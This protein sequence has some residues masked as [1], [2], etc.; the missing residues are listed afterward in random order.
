MNNKPYLFCGRFYN[1]TK[2]SIVSRMKHMV[3]T[4]LIIS[5]HRK[6][7]KNFVRNARTQ[8][9]ACAHQWIDTAPLIQHSINPVI[10]W[11]GHATF[12]IQ[13]G[14]LNI[15]TDPAFFEISPLIPRFLPSP[16][17]LQQLPPIDLILISHNHRDHMDEQ[18][19]LTLSKHRPA[20]F[21]PLGNVTWLLTR[22]FNKAKEFTWWDETTI[23]KNNTSLRI[24]FL[25]AEHWTGRGL[26]DTNRSLWGSW[27]I[28]YNNTNIY[29]AGDTAWGSHFTAINQKFGPLLAAMLPISPYQPRTLLD[30]CH[31]DAPQSIQALAA[32][33]AQ[34]MFPMHWGTFM[35]GTDSFLGPIEQLQEQ[36]A[37]QQSLIGT[38][39][40]HVCKFCE[41]QALQ[42]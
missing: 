34:H 32:L 27:M 12:L 8:A 35:F 40:L 41:P 10:T 3:H 37:L 28:T 24:T 11:L 20:V 9:A 22:G 4:S 42:P 19:M 31:L 25:P 6:N 1:N 5:K 23:T 26:W 13:V 36:W 14:G 29:F 33:D 30:E 2:D 39:H 38:K 18:S 16:I 15:L 17:D 7:N 21:A